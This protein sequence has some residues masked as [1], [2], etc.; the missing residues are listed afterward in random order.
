MRGGS[1]EIIPIQVRDAAHTLRD[2]YRKTS[3]P[4]P[5]IPN[6]SGLWRCLTPLCNASIAEPRYDPSIVLTYVFESSRDGS[7][8]EIIKTTLKDYLLVGAARPPISFHERVGKHSNVDANV[9]E[10]EARWATGHPDEE[11]MG[12]GPDWNWK[13]N[14]QIRH[15][16]VVM[17]AFDASVETFIHTH[18][19]WDIEKDA[20]PAMNAFRAEYTTLLNGIPYV[21]IVNY[22]EVA[23]KW[24][25]V[26]YA[27]KLQQVD[28]SLGAEFADLFEAALAIAVRPSI[29]M[30]CWEW[31]WYPTEDGQGRKDTTDADKYRTVDLSKAHMRKV[32]VML[33]KTES[34]YG[35]RVEWITTLQE[36]DW[37]KT[38]R[39]EFG[40]RPPDFDNVRARAKQLV[41]ESP[42][43]KS[44]NKGTFRIIDTGIMVG[45][46]GRIIHYTQECLA[47][48]DK[49]PGHCYCGKPFVDPV[50]QKIVHT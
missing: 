24:T 34:D 17:E 42:S 49:R 3:L 33:D 45:P 22:D 20:V 5:L 35:Q 30:R 48:D 26:P 12:S 4:H 28:V 8:T 14:E 27:K 15:S 43:K 9:D 7:F 38:L 18:G 2:W 16:D 6:A 40:P 47:I 50:T 41:E 10:F 32:D 13:E 44:K 36:K 31:E 21:V 37:L 39:A 11:D 23:T 19:P 25:N 1:R 29:K 46:N